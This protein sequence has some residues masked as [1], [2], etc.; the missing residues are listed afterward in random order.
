MPQIASISHDEW[1]FFWVFCHF[2]VGT[3]LRAL[4]QNP[5][6]DVKEE[7]KSCHALF[8][9]QSTISLESLRAPSLN[10]IDH[11]IKIQSLAVITTLLTSQSVVDGYLHQTIQIRPFRKILRIFPILRYSSWQIW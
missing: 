2:F 7:R 3:F 11:P 8:L 1:L 10:D 5:N 4:L 6:I 9:D